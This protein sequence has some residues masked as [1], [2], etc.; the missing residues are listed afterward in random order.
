MVMVPQMGE[1]KGKSGCWGG[2]RRAAP[3]PRPGGRLPCPRATRGAF[4]APV[5]GKN[6]PESAL[7]DRSAILSIQAESTHRKL[8]VGGETF[9]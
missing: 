4:Y 1:K 8:A 2:M 7:V 6:A 9:S 5:V 3:G